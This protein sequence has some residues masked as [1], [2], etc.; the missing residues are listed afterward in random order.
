MQ[1]SVNEQTV[2]CPQCGFDV[3]VTESLAAPM[4]AE[5]TQKYEQQARQQQQ[6][7][8]TR[9]QELSKQANALQQQKADAERRVADQVKSQLDKERTT[10][11]EQEAER[12]KQRVAEELGRQASE[13][14]ERDARLELLAGKLKTAQEQEADFL[15][16]KR[17]L[18]DQR[19][20]LKLQVE[21]QVQLEV[22]AVRQ[23]AQRTA[24]EQTQLRLQDKDNDIKKLREEIEKLNRKAEQG[25]AQARGEV[26]EMHLEQQL[27]TRFP[28]DDIQP[29]PKGEFGGDLLHTVRDAT[30]Q[31]C[32]SILW[33]FKRTQKWSDGWLAKL[34]G[35][36]RAAGAELAVIVTQALPKDITHFDHLDGI[37]VSS[38]SC[39]LPVAVSL[40]QALVELARARRAGQGQETKVQQVYSYLTGPQFRHRVATIAEKFTDMRADLDDEKRFLQK[41]W[42]KREKQ[43]ELVLEASEGMYGDLQGIAGRSL[44]EIDALEPQ[45]LLHDES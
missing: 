26:L 13:L 9:E 4:I 45:M 27:R 34:R 38:L 33:E 2:K 44:Q 21:K 10:F 23:Q 1:T 22:D 30:G 41:K 29:V 43:L 39:T 40:R 14:K 28:T 11:I 5:I 6:A 37:W 8:A 42:A 3:K 31:P 35:D 12:A 15:R 17:D 36:Q 24:E 25:S 16:Q 32:G 7:M 18:D 19:R 20:E